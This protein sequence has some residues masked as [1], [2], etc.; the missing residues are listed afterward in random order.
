M[1]LKCDDGSIPSIVEYID[2]DKW[3]CV[4]LYAD[5]LEFRTQGENFGLW[6]FQNENV[7]QG[8]AYRYYDTLHF[9]SRNH[10]SVTDMVSLINELS[11]KCITGEEWLIEAV[12][13]QLG[14]KYRLEVN[15]II[16]LSHVLEERKKFS[17]TRASVDDVP[18]IATIK[19]I[20]S[21][22]PIRVSANK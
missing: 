5:M 18:E 4:Y 20:T 9:Y 13:P 15:H 11:P 17:F 2:Q 14:N 22:L 16:T 12:V 6:V 19:F 1:I 3:K 10:V 7:I 21:Y 8:V